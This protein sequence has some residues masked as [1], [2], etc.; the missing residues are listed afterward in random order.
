MLRACG[1]RIDAVDDRGRT[2]LYI[3]A[4][5][6]NLEVLKWL[7]S[8]GADPLCC[9]SDGRSALHAAAANGHRAA[10]E[11][12]FSGMRLT[13]LGRALGMED[14]IGHTAADLAHA[15]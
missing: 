4:A 2:A 3:A 6:G 10:C 1:A 9:A 8:N 11:E 13:D 12:L 5:E 14:H 15:A 7:L